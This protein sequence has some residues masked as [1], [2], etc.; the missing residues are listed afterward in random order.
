MADENKL[1]EAYIEVVARLDKFDAQLRD[2]ERNVKNSA[3]RTE[4]ATDKFG[5]A[6]NRATSRLF[7]LR[8]A[9][10]AAAGLTGMFYFTQ[11]ML[12]AAGSIGETAMKLGVTTDQLQELRFAARQSGS[13]IEAMDT[14]LKFLN[15]NIGEAVTG[16]KTMRAEFEALGINLTDNTGKTKATADVFLEL[17][18]RIK[19]IQDP[20]VQTK[21]ILDLLGRSGNDLKNVLLEG[22]GGL[23]GL[24][25]QAHELG[26]VLEKDAIAKA[27]ATS[28]R[29]GVLFDVIKVSGMNLAIAFVPVM[30]SIVD[31]FTNKDFQEGVKR[32]ASWISGMIDFAVRNASQFKGVLNAID[33]VVNGA[34]EGNNLTGMR[35]TGNPQVRR[36]E[37]Q[38]KANQEELDVLKRSGTPNDAPDMVYRN[39][40]VADIQRRLRQAKE[41]EAAYLSTLDTG[42]SAGTGGGMGTGGAPVF[43][44]EK[45]L[46]DMENA[47][48][49]KEVDKVA[50]SIKELQFALEQL[51]KT[52][53][54]QAIGDALK[55]VGADDPRYDRIRN[56]AAAYYDLKKA[57]DDQKKAQE[58]AKQIIED[59]LTPLEQ[60]NAYV[61]HLSELMVTGGLTAEGFN[62]GVAKAKDTLEKQ[63]DALSNLKSAAQ[64]FGSVWSSAFEEAIFAAESLQDVLKG[65]LQ[66]LARVALRKFVTGPLTDWFV[67]QF[68]SGGRVGGKGT[69]GRSVSPLLFA[70]APRYHSGTPGAGLKSGE[71]PAILQKGEQVIP[72]GSRMGVGGI[73]LNLTV[74]ASG[75]SREQ[76]KDLASQVGQVV[77]RVIEDKVLSVIGREMRPG[78]MLA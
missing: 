72:R 32:V 46:Q 67:G 38:L 78:G 8:T 9:A 35:A 24:A 53:R 7:S 15:N 14:A 2:V 42:A 39:A 19:G 37:E 26:L 12:D 40:Q 45:F 47:G 56:L 6:I 60:Y 17:A 69:L 30:E 52:E 33:M 4:R 25:E 5:A 73:M 21:V 57:Q 18:D 75:G 41:A 51:G 50:A 48:G 44:I 61:K 76:N 62:R 59:T 70:G 36:L 74:N 13:S 22:A 68:H 65:L 58:E 23:K 66:D 34:N 29:L 71:M 28:D 1:G 11:K 54:D 3:E 16:N 55:G 27:K 20:A 43:D 64:D 31:L 10:V 63:N 49:S 77:E